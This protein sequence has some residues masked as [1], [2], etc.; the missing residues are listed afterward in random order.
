MIVLP[1]VADLSA[2]MR[3]LN[4]ILPLAYV[5]MLFFSRDATIVLSEIYNGY[6]GDTI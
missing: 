6:L 3:R 4:F 2:K 1:I 5:A